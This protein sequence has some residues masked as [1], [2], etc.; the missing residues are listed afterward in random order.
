[1][2]LD[3][4]PAARYQPACGVRLVRTRQRHAG[5]RPKAVGG[6][7]LAEVDLVVTAMGYGLDTALRPRTGDVPVAKAVPR[8]VD[9]RW[10]ASGLLAN[11][12]PAFA[13]HQPVGELA[14]G[15][16]TVR[17]A[18]AAPRSPRVWVAGDALTGPATVV[19]AMA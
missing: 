19:D 18:A 15:R 12:A 7:E 9:R 10:V 1:M 11:P 4:G 16:E 17:Y 14:I 6:G 2:P 8:F 5:D 13:R 3:G